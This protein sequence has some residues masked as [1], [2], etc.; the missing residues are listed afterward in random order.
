M[1]PFDLTIKWANHNLVME[2][3]VNENYMTTDWSEVFALSCREARLH[4]FWVISTI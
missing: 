3:Y 2:S 4:G 1:K